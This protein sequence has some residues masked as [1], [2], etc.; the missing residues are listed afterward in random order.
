VI[1]TRRQ[2]ALLGL[3]AAGVALAT[4]VFYVSLIASEGDPHNLDRVVVVATVI[5]A[6]AATAVAGSLV[7]A[8][9][10]RAL[11]LST[12]AVTLVV[13]GAIGVFSIGAF[14]LLSGVLAGLAAARVPGARREVAAA[15]AV[16]AAVFVLSIAA[17]V[18]T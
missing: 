15:A 2:F 14:L 9:N 8:P 7:G 17:L 4:D 18:L 5:A 1:E 12:A 13:W 11:L 3:T 6:A 16:A 10:V